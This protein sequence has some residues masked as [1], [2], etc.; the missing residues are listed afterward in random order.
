LTKKV[1]IKGWKTMPDKLRVGILGAGWA[2]G[3]HAK[4]FSRLRDVEVLALWSRTRARAESLA[5][6][7][8]EPKLQI[9]DHWQDLIESSKVDIISLA[10]PPT[11]RRE[12]VDMALV[13]GCH[14]LVEKPFSVGLDDART[15][16]HAA[17]QAAMVTV[18][19]FNWRYAPGCQAAWREIQ[20][21][22]IGRILDVRMEWRL[23]GLPGD[24]FKQRP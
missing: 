15:M 5:N 19:S 18:V 12:P 2:G 22:N 3:G 9:Y 1:V 7:L 6:E 8:A 16:V 24:F 14:V 20:E 21:G 11:L 4:A 23:S 13:H 10:T 17:R